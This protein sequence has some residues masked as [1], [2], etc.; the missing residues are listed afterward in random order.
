ML[1]NLISLSVASSNDTAATFAAAGKNLND[2]NTKSADKSAL[3]LVDIPAPEQRFKEFELYFNQILSHNEIKT[4]KDGVSQ[5]DESNLLSDEETDFLAGQII[6]F[7]SGPVDA[8]KENVEITNAASLGLDKETIIQIIDTLPTHKRHDF[9]TAIEALSALEAP[10]QLGAAKEL[11]PLEPEVQAL[12]DVLEKLKKQLETTSNLD[13]EGEPEAS[14]NLNQKSSTVEI[15]R[16]REVRVGSKEQQHAELKSS[17]NDGVNNKNTQET[18]RFDGV[19]GKA[20]ADTLQVN[21]RES[22]AKDAEKPGVAVDDFSVQA[23]QPKQSDNVV[24]AKTHQDEMLNVSSRTQREETVSKTASHSGEEQ[25]ASQRIKSKRSAFN[26]QDANFQA[27][28][29]T[30]QHA[31]KSLASASEDVKQFESLDEIK[32][33]LKAAVMA[34]PLK[35]QQMLKQKLAAQSASGGKSQ[36]PEQ[37]LEQISESKQKVI[38][39]SSEVNRQTV[40]SLQSVINLRQ[41]IE[42][43]KNNNVAETK[44]FLA[45]DD[46]LELAKNN[47]VNDAKINLVESGKNTQVTSMTFESMIKQIEGQGK[48]SAETQSLGHIVNTRLDQQELL[49]PASTTT[50]QTPKTLNDQLMQKIPLH[51]QF[52]TNN[53]KERVGMMVNGGISQAVIALDPEELG[54]M[55]IRIVMQQDQLNVQFQVQN[56]AAKEMLE[57]AMGKLKDMLDE[58]G[59]ALGQSD[60]EQQ[61]QQ[62]QSEALLQGELAD[63]DDEFDADGEPVTLVLHKQSANGIDYYA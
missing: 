54:A 17:A 12:A 41:P 4:T 25:V 27:I 34:L 32:S 2:S 16:T 61:S 31:Q 50:T 21:E 22:V 55:S 9:I 42:H 60:V 58:Q 1:D 5:A 36:T 29:K 62:E 6:A 33:E 35:E 30:E 10:K 63:I 13:A 7:F 24:A 19:A 59:I 46:E 37:I 20:V 39:E 57:Q 40:A 51:E 14:H 15:E 49:A 18:Q 47:L 52:A 28:A 44:E 8:E 23:Q 26:N 45:T 56:P 43:S 3:E 11:P 38:I 48:N 53:L